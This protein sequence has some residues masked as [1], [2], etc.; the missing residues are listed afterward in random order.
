MKQRCQQLQDAL[1]T[2]QLNDRDALYAS[3]N[4]ALCL[5]SLA[6]AS[7]QL[8]IFA[9]DLQEAMQKSAEFTPPPPPTPL[10]PLQSAATHAHAQTHTTDEDGAE[11]ETPQSAGD[12][13]PDSPSGGA[14]SRLL[15]AQQQQ[16]ETAHNTA[17]DD[18]EEAA[19]P[20]PSLVTRKG[21][22]K[23]KAKATSAAAA[24]PAAE[25]AA[26]S[27]M[28][29]VA[30]FLLHHKGTGSDTVQLGEIINGV[31]TTF[32]AKDVLS[33]CELLSNTDLGNGKCAWFNST[34][35]MIGF[36]QCDEDD[37]DE[38][39]ASPNAI[40]FNILNRPM[41]FSGW[42]SIGMDTVI[43]WAQKTPHVDLQQVTN[44]CMELNRTPLRLGYGDFGMDL[45]WNSDRTATFKMI[46]KVPMIVLGGN[47]AD[48]QRAIEK[49]QLQQLQRLQRK[50][51]L[52][53]ENKE[54]ESSTTKKAKKADDGTE[55]A[56]APPPSLV[57]G[58]GKGKAKAKA[59]ATSVPVPH[60][61][62]A[63]AE[64]AATAATAAAEETGCEV[65]C[66]FK[67]HVQG[68]KFIL[69]KQTDMGY[70]KNN[71]AHYKKRCHFCKMGMKFATKYVDLYFMLVRPSTTDADSKAEDDIILLPD[72]GD[73]IV[74]VKCH[75]LGN[76]GTGAPERKRNRR[77]SAK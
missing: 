65:Q 22:A 25:A 54:A 63:A 46:D 5:R 45:T 28:G 67:T 1:I 74:C 58:K 4:L 44:A 20:P 16:S 52:D 21:K 13:R 11:D 72:E 31:G 2:C 18:T 3:P 77:S 37:D 41:Y 9:V 8:I 30:S 64:P 34:E 26:E 24:E 29:A 6:G 68:G 75:E 61:R 43:D 23:A 73:N 69:Q 10:A 60:S 35:Q 7:E 40:V 36:Q 70:L 14:I 66:W 27:A 49:E 12:S 42:S 33:A 51:Q 15:T 71:Y 38:W 19:A 59:K 55:E 57:K 53:E 32:V 47:E 62:A 48:K 39:A 50:R 17:D 56:A 76:L